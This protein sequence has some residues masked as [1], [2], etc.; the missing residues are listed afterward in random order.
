MKL[1]KAKITN[2]RGICDTVTIDFNDFNTIVGQNDAGKS[3]ILKAL[4]C[5]LNE[6]AIK[7]EDLNKS[8]ENSLVT[9][10]LFFN[11]E[12]QKIVIDE[13]IETS[14]EAEEL[15]ND[16]NLLVVTKTWDTSK[17]RITSD[18]KI[19]RKKYETS[20]C[21]LLTETQLIALCGKL[22]IETHK[23]NNDEFNNVEKRAK[24]RN[25]NNEKNVIS[26]FVLEDLPTVGKSR[27]K[28]I[29]DAVKISLPEF[30]YFKADTSLSETDT[31]IQNFFKKIAEDTI[32][33]EINKGEIESIV[34]DS[35]GKVLDKITEKINLVVESSEMVAP[36]IKFD[37]SKLVSTSF[38]SIKDETEMPLTSRG[39]GFRRITMMAYFEHLA[40][41]NKEE[42]QDIIF[43]FEEPETFLHPSAQEKL[44][45]RLASMAE[46]NYQVIITTHSS[47]IVANSNKAD[48]CHVSRSDGHYAIYQHIEN[49]NPIVE[50][51]GI[52][53]DNQFLN[54]FDSARVLF[55]VEG[56][57]DVHA[58][59]HTAEK[60]KQN[61]RIPNTFNDLNI[62]I[63]PIGGCDSIK[64][65]VTL[66]LL[67]KINKP[68]FIFQDSDKTTHGEISPNHTKLI[69]DG[70]VHNVNFLVSKKRAIENYIH[71]A[72]LNRIVPG[73]GI[74]YGDWDDVKDICK[75]HPQ[76]GLLG[77]KKVVARHFSKLT[78]DELRNAFFDGH[79]DEFLIVWQKVVDL[80]PE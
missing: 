35:V 68:Y 33:K 59:T 21:L 62:V 29:L 63:I 60:Y 2:F 44:F 1:I 71:P 66:D 4:D 40:E 20:D 15:V 67:N 10:E 24:I 28:S 69:A 72:A 53:V 56:I 18:T 42:H 48:I 61:D 77:G 17:T 49:I 76:N 12:N 41:Q 3:T 31:A 43:G 8:A 46:N 19:V 39:D 55:L 14:F 25:D 5:F 45:A 79:E 9:I 57:D 80:I 65:W 52:T 37:W 34:V 6:T 7:P 38:K 75:L 70:F 73:A 58:F 47:I 74:A 54:V 30:E 16:E 22:H 26:E 11:P 78:F 36:S 13:N 51:L 50:D 64:H 23:A 27:L 32:A